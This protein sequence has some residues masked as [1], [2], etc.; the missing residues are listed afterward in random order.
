MLL[1]RLLILRFLSLE[2]QCS[3]IAPEAAAS[4]SPD[5]LT[6]AALNSSKPGANP[7]VWIRVAAE[8]ASEK[9]NEV[10]LAKW[11]DK[12]RWPWTADTNV[13][14]MNLCVQS[15]PWWG[16]HKQYIILQIYIITYIH[17]IYI[18]SC[19]SI[20]HLVLRNTHFLLH[21]QRVHTANLVW[22]ASFTAWAPPPP[23]PP[24]ISVC[25]RAAARAAKCQW[26]HWWGMNILP[27]FSHPALQI[28]RMS[29]LQICVQQKLSNSTHLNSMKNNWSTFL[30]YFPSPV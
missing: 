7:V 10:D 15:L 16:D 23:P 18:Y 22:L 20:V 25:F 6:N 19:I 24:H 27:C 29:L 26:K 17:G 5:L 30:D 8:C 2:L 21:L 3:R 13:L 4:Q 12:L 11:F 1:V 9:A 28:C 14:V